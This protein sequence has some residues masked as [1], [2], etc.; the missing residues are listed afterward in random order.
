M[1]GQKVDTMV[2]YSVAALV[3]WLA[4]CSDVHL[5]VLWVEM[6]AFRWAAAM[7]ALK[8]V[9]KDGCSVACWVAH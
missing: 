4:V 8:A 7:A 3:E 5:V 6:M 9:R 2:A 1:V